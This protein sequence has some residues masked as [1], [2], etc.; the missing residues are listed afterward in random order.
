MVLGRILGDV[1]LERDAGTLEEDHLARAVVVGGIA[2]VRV[3]EA[4]EIR[5]DADRIASGVDVLEDARIPDAFLA[6]AVR[7]VV[8]EIAE[9][10]EQ[11]ALADARAAD[12]RDAHQSV[13]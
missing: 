13:S 12:N 8:V 7:S 9:L 6:L 2:V 5:G 3:V 4:A 11:R 10:A 1:R